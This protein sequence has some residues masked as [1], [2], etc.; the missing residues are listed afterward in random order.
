[1]VI[2]KLLILL[3]KTTLLKLIGG[4]MYGGEFS[5]LRGINR[6]IP[7]ERKTYDEVGI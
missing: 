6:L 7:E 2:S 5:G 4:Q 1:M 3:G